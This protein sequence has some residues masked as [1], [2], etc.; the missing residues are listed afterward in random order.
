MRMVAYWEVVQKRLVDSMALHLQLSIHK[1]VNKELEKYIVSELMHG[2]GG[3][4]GDWIERL[5][6]ESPS[7]A[8]KRV[9]LTATINKLKECKEILAKITHTIDSTPISV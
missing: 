5:M 7:V 9:K 2:V 4:G 1:L 8:A 3:Q 6:E